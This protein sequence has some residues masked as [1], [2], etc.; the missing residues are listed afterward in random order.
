MHPASPTP[1]APS[2]LWGAGCVQGKDINVWHVAGAWD[3]VVHQR[4]GDELALFVINELLHQGLAQ[5]LGGA[6]DELP[7]GQGGLHNMAL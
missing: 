1:L 5:T 7:V 6:T 3:G 4:A 2:K